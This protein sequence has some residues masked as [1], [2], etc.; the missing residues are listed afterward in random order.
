MYMY[1]AS[2]LAE[3]SNCEQVGDEDIANLAGK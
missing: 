3:S 1:H 2:W